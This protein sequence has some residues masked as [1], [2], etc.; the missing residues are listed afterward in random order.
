MSKYA[1][2]VEGVLIPAPT[3]VIK[4]GFIIKNPKESLLKELGYKPIKY[5]EIPEITTPGNMIKEVYTDQGDYIQVSYKEYTPDSEPIIPEPISTEESRELLAFAKMAV[6]T[7]ELTDKQ[8]LSIKNMY[9]TWKDF[10]GKNLEVGFKVLYEDRL[11]K[12]KQKII[13][14]L[15]NQ[16]PSI[17]TAA[18]YEEVNEINAGT[19][20]DPIPYNN[21]MELKERKY[22]SQG[23]I[24]Y[25]CTRSTGQPVY[26]N[27]SDLVNIYVTKVE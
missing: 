14:V 5:D 18:I 20:E 15:E 21:N 19:L 12:V 23:G 6:N 2:L 24:T 27:L 13:T 4:D 8:S 10:V 26:N 9:P 7:V 3:Q 17:S 22:Y 11:Y 16:P 1:Q 25:L